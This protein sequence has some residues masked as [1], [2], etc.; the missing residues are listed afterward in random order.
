M[1]V[2]PEF[3]KQADNL[4]AYKSS[5][6]SAVSGRASLWSMVD[7]AADQVYEDRVKGASITTVDGRLDTAEVGDKVREWFTLHR[8][9]FNIDSGLTAGS[10]PTAISSVDGAFS[11]YGWR[12]S[13]YFND[14]HEENL[15][16]TLSAENVWPKDNFSLGVVSATGS[17]AVTLHTDGTSSTAHTNGTLNAG[18]INLTRTSL[19]GVIVGVVRNGDIGGANWTVT[20][21]GLSQPGATGTLSVAFPQIGSGTTPGNSVTL[22]VA[23]ITNAVDSAGS[24]LG[25]HT[26]GSGEGDAFLTGGWALLSSDEKTPNAQELVQIDV[27]TSN[28]V[29]FVAAP[30]T[31]RFDGTADTV[32]LTPL[33][34]AFTGATATLGTSGDDL[35]I[36]FGND[37]T[38]SI[39]ANP[40]SSGW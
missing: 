12:T 24:G 14:L 3:M 38:L 32:T 19:G 18:A 2:E 11:S 8:D 7:A 4:A 21:T 9:Y 34:S 20:L 27:A 15:G 40:T 36:S 5:L 30:T 31:G 25:P 6:L 39:S 13:D 35:E 22:G 26:V 23:T 33:Y 10:P 17:G 37:R 16:S 28:S 29:T 1:P